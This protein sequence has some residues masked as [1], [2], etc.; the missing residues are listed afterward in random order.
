MQISKLGSF[1]I[2]GLF[3]RF[4]SSELFARSLLFFLFLLSSF[5]NF[6][7]FCSKGHSLLV[8]FL[9]IAQT[10]RLIATLQDIKM[11]NHA[12]VF[13]FVIGKINSKEAIKY[14]SKQCLKDN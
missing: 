1:P 8:F 10:T 3:P 7:S 6:G 5:S 9:T 13:A 11:V 2:S 4:P 14:V 12:K